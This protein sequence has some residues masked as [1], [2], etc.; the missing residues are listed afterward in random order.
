LEDRMFWAGSKGWEGCL[1]F[2]RRQ[3][4]KKKMNRTKKTFQTEATKFDGGP[5][6]TLPPRWFQNTV[7]F[8]K[9]DMEKNGTLGT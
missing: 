1:L 8:E 9:E 4:K 7:F 2:V 3:K 5:G 6:E